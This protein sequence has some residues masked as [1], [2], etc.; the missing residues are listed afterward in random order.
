MRILKNAFMTNQS[1]VDD[2]LVM[3]LCL[4]FK[5]RFCWMIH[6]KKLLL[7]DHTSMTHGCQKKRH[8]YYEDCIYDKS[9][10]GWW[11]S[12]DESMA[13]WSR[14]QTTNSLTPF[15]IFVIFRPNQNHFHFFLFSR[16]SPTFLL[17]YGCEKIYYEKSKIAEIQ[18]MWQMQGWSDTHRH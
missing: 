9:I 6:F 3:M 13:G 16:F 1:G 4:I 2:S 7:I 15:L 12:C 8:A 14:W 5:K 11:Q 17:H 18:N 10:R